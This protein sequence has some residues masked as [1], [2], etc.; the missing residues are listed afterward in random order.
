MSNSQVSRQR[1]ANAYKAYCAALQVQSG[2]SGEALREYIRETV[3]QSYLVLFNSKEIR[4]RDLNPEQLVKL[5]L[6]RESMTNL[7]SRANA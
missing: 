7:M 1:Q 6:H 3:R 4:Q 5:C 2:L